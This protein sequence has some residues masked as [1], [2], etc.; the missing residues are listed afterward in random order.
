MVPA[1]WA[2]GLIASLYLTPHH[3]VVAGLFAVPMLLV[4]YQAAPPVAGAV[5]G[6]SAALSVAAALVDDVPAQ[7]WSFSLMAL[8]LVGLLSVTVSRERLRAAARTNEA[9]LARNQLQQ[10][11]EAI[12]HSMCDPLLVV[13]A[14]SHLVASDAPEHQDNLRA[15]DQAVES[16]RRFAEDMTDAAAIGAGRLRIEPSPFNATELAER[17]VQ[18]FAGSSGASQIE[19]QAERALAVWW[20]RRRSEQLLTKLVQNAVRH[21]PRGSHIRVELTSS[22]GEVHVT[23]A[24]QSPG[25][26]SERLPAMFQPFSVLYP[27]RPQGERDSGVDLYI[28]QAI[29]E[30][31]G[32]RIWVEPAGERGAIFHVE[33]PRQA[34]FQRVYNEA[35]KG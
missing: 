13:S 23:I 14:R 4:A 10:F 20:D 33:M 2:V 9:E 30:A 19:L 29:V 26:P 25:I 21:S 15:I 12:S 3:Y 22:D 18:G 1:L 7:V 31:H 24:D 6:I 27:A 28:C 8:V 34:P 16:L 11:T 17:V 32:G 35:P 5:S